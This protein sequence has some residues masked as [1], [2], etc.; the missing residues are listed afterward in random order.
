MTTVLQESEPLPMMLLGYRRL[1]LWIWVNWQRW[2]HS[3]LKKRDTS[4][5]ILP[6]EQGE[7][8]QRVQSMQSFCPPAFYKICFQKHTILAKIKKSSDLS[9]LPFSI[10]I[11]TH[12][13][14]HIVRFTKCMQ[15]FVATTHDKMIEALGGHENTDHILGNI[16]IPRLASVLDFYNSRHT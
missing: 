10:F 15:P 8:G 7:K 2:W 4:Y 13:L 3:T 14:G 16:Q 6:N 9:L 11:V 1:K 5:P 12:E